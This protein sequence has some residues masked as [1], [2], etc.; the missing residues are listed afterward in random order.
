MESNNNNN[1]NFDISN[2]NNEKKIVVDRI[3]ILL[4]PKSPSFS[5]SVYEGTKNGFLCG[6]GVGLAVP[7]LFRGRVEPVS[8]FM[9]SVLNLTFIGTSFS[10]TIHILQYNLLLPPMSSWTMGGLLVGGTTAHLLGRG[11][12]VRGMFSGGIFGA[13]GYLVNKKL[14]KE[15]TDRN[16]IADISELKEL[17]EENRNKNHN[18]ELSPRDQHLYNRLMEGIDNRIS[19]PAFNKDESPITFSKVIKSLSPFK[20]ITEEEKQ[21]IIQKNKE[22]DNT[23]VLD[24]KGK[25]RS[26]QQQQQNNNN[27]NNNNTENNK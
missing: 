14:Y 3:R 24:L 5:N 23:T 15:E 11:G 22:R 7:I 20:E 10:S 4:H 2:D 6:V 9:K 12:F 27:N 19:D 16:I 21:L 8:S 18:I 25:S 1:N 17:V 26:N 13:L